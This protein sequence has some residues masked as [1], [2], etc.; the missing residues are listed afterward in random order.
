MIKSIYETI[1]QYKPKILNMEIGKHITFGYTEDGQY[2]AIPVKRL[3]ENNYR[4][5]GL[6]NINITDINSVKYKYTR[7]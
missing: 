2:H 3:D 6:H 1:K 5:D 7:D 4:F